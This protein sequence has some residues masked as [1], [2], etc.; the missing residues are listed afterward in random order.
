MKLEIKN[1]FLTRK[2]VKDDLNKT[3]N[4]NFKY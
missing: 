1:Q 2:L 3:K 4:F